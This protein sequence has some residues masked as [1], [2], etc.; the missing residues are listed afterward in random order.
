MCISNGN[1]NAIFYQIILI[2]FT[3]KLY[4]LK[5]LDTIELQHAEIVCNDNISI[6][7]VLYKNRSIKTNEKCSPLYIK[8]I[9]SSNI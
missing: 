8:E 6:H 4:T 5:L 9:K 7:N 1:E 2:S 3:N